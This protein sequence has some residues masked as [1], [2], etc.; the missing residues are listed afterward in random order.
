[1]GEDGSGRSNAAAPW[2]TTRL[3]YAW[4]APYRWVFISLGEE[5]SVEITR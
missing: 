4:A 5:R 1:M 3:E 2:S